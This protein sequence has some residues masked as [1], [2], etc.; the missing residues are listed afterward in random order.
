[1]KTDF[2]SELMPVPTEDMAWQ[3]LALDGGV[4][5]I[6]KQHRRVVFPNVTKE[7]LFQM[8]TAVKLEPE[9]VIDNFTEQ[10]KARVGANFAI[11]TASG[12]SSLH[13]AL[14]GAGV[15][16]GDE[17]LVPAFTFIATAQ[18]VVAA[19]AIPVFVDIEPDTWCMNPFELEAHI[20]PKTRAV[21]PVHVHGLPAN[22]EALQQLCDRK[23][24]L[25][26]EDASH[27]HSA[28]YN[29]RYCGSL[30]DAAGQSLMAD[31]NFPLGGEGGIAFF[32][33]KSSYERAKAFLVR[34]GLDY[35]ISWIAAAFGTSQLE[36]LDYYDKVRQRN[37]K[38]LIDALNQTRLFKGPSTPS[39]CVHSYNMFRIQVNTELPDFKGIPN[40]KVKAAVQRLLNEEGVAVREWQNTLLPF[41]LPFKN[42]IGF[43][44][45]YPFS[46]TTRR[47]YSL[48]DFPV[49]CTMLNTTL[50]LCRELRSPVEYE[51][52]MSY[53][54]AF[55]KVANN[56][57]RI[58]ELANEI[59]VMAP[60]SHDARLG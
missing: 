49:A 6:S 37:A 4:P 15:Q 47:A 34:S 33:E 32:K 57:S 59:D 27:A 43:G 11:A 10:Y 28:T 12:T 23:G 38:M 8:M 44:E 58:A 30:G 60:A 53:A 17:V 40:Y 16:P 54:M 24:L 29:G 13:L 1:M 48:S 55:K 18:A 19:K 22:M 50:V 25:L 31:K 3:P 5:V 9:V 20:T 41:H 26:I 2:I 45:G 14:V 7:D 35:G 56:L 21:M 42:Q 39:D 52:V 36:R 46:L 51:R